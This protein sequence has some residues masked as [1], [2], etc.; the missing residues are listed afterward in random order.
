MAMLLTAIPSWSAFA[1]D[2]NSGNAPAAPAASTSSADTTDQISLLKK[3]MALQQQQIEQMQKA[4]AEQNQLLDQLTKTA[5][6]TA[7]AAQPVQP[8]KPAP[9]VQQASQT[10]STS[11]GVVAST[12]PVIPQNQNKTENAISSSSDSNAR[13]IYVGATPGGGD[14]TSPLQIHIGDATLIPVGFMDFTSVWRNHDTNGSIATNFGNIPYA[15]TTAYAPNLSEFRLSTENSR[16]GFRADAMIHGWHVMGYMEADFHGN[17]AAS[18]AVSTNSNTL[19]ER[20][21]WVDLNSGHF[22]LLGGQTWSLA[23]PG[24]SGISPLPADIFY[25]QDTDVNYQAGLVFGRIPEL[26]FVWHPSKKVAWAFAIDSPDQYAGGNGGAGN[27]VLPALL[28]TSATYQGELDYNAGNTLSTPNVAPDII[29]KLAFDPSKRV[30]VEI[31][32]MERNFKVYDPLTTEVNS[33]EG[34]AVA[35]NAGLE[36]VKGLRFLTNDYWSD[37]GGRYIYG[38]VPDLIAHAN[39]TLSLIHASSTVTGFEFTHRKTM[40]Y[41]YYGGIYAQKNTALDANGTTLIGY[42]MESGANATNAQNR[43]VQEATFGFNQTI[44][45]N[46]KYGAVNFMGQYSYLLRDPWFEK[47]GVQPNANVNMLF[48]NLRYTLPGSA[49][50][51]GK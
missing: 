16:I 9:V 20:L 3:K 25:S 8:A 42:G 40:L 5:A 18:V 36:I 15:S 30:H 38:Q 44:W 39:G 49:P 7:Q 1:A 37:G 48:F 31:M 12:T 14:D 17:N 29:T 33:A 51:M 11:L 47:P 41:T 43:N 6:P 35:F 4:L 13:R 34:G 10:Q 22:E 23:T 50:T 24:R 27:I 2:G 45:K 46:G 19:R 32:G 26:R 21:Y 28:N